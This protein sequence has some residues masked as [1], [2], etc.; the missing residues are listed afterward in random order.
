MIGK[1]PL[2]EQPRKEQPTQKP[3][4]TTLEQSV[5][6]VSVAQLDVHPTDDQEFAGSTPCGSAT[7]FRGD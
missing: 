5:V 6:P 1:K 7:F 2:T 4:P 3:L